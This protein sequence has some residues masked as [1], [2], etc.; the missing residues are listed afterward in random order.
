MAAL[1]SLV[2]AAVVQLPVTSATAAVR[3]PSFVA[4]WDLGSGG[5]SNGVAVAPDG[6]VYVAYSLL[7]KVVKLSPDG[8]LLDTIG[9]LGHG[10]GQFSHPDGVAVDGDGTVYVTDSSD[11]RVQMFDADGEFVAAW[12]TPGSGIGEFDEPQGIAVDA[13]GNVYVAD[14]QNF[15][16]QKFDSAGNF[17][18]QWG[19]AG[20]GNG[21]F[22]DLNGPTHVAVAPTSGHVYVTDVGNDRV[23]EFTSTGGFVRA[24]GSTGV[25]KGQFQNPVGVAVDADGYVYVVEAFGNRVQKFTSTGTFVTKWGTT[26]TGNGQFDSPRGVAAGAEGQV[27]VTDSDNERVEVFQNLARPDGRIRRGAGATVGNG[28]YG[29]T[30]AGQRVAGSAGRGAT[31]TYYA[32]LE[33]EAPFADT[34]RLRGGASSTHYR[35]RYRNPAGENITTDVVNGTFE[36]PPLAPKATFTVTIRVTVLTTAP[37]GSSLSRLLT[38]I[39]TTQPAERDAVKFLTRRA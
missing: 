18:L 36:T 14:S 9:S 12:G 38:A 16:V 19:S 2:S 4:S 17:L 25:D 34:L 32:T 29:T 5:Y 15:R 22:Q 6:N 27:Y 23:Q 35:V 11:D 33:N 1:A 31:V 7:P 13:D 10:D 30:G 39:S 20:D 21:Q 3:A 8:V 26:G 37:S 28:I 24:W